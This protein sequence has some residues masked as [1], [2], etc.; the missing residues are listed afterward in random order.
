[1]A[2]VTESCGFSEGEMGRGTGGGAHTLIEGNGRVV[3]DG[4]AASQS[5]FP[6]KMWSLQQQTG[7]HLAPSVEGINPRVLNRWWGEVQRGRVTFRVT[8]RVS[9][10]TGTRSQEPLVEAARNQWIFL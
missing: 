1:M 10:R 6:T 3:A 8:W 7:T 9:V 4:R 2:G 5:N